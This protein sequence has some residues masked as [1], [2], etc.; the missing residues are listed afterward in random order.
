MGG[1]ALT[2]L[3]GSA[4][5]ESSETVLGDLRREQVIAWLTLLAVLWIGRRWVAGSHAGAG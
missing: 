1:Y 5:H 2:L 3:I 4:W